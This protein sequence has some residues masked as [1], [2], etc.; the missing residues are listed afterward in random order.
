MSQEPNDKRH[1]PV[2][3]N[4]KANNIK[5]Q[6]N[7]VSL[8]SAIFVV[9]LVAVSSFILGARGSEWVS[10]FAASGGNRNKTAELDYAQLDALYDTL[11]TSYVGDLDNQKLIDGAKKGMAQATGDPYTEYFTDAEADEFFGELSGEFSGIGA[12]LGKKDEQLTIIST[13]D[14]TPA[15]KAGLKAGDVIAQVNEEDTQAWSIEEAVSNIRGEKGTTV[16]LTVIRE[17]EVLS[18]DVVRDDIVNPSVRSEVLD[19]N[20]GYIRLSR[21][22]DTDTV[23]LTR[24]FA[25]DLKQ[26]GVRGIV[27]D[28]RGNG[29]GYVK[30]AQEVAGVWLEDGKVVVEERQ[31]DKVLETL[32]ASGNPIL[33]GVP[34]V[35]LVDGGSASASEIVA[36]AFKD[37]GIATLVG[38][39]TFG[40]GSV[41]KIEQLTGGGQLKVTIAKWYTPKGQNIDKQGIEPKDKVELTEEDV[42][43]SRDPQ[44]DKAVE[45]LRQ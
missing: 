33:N 21:F 19:G 44:R 20:I 37:Y 38:Q 3:Q 10:T 6:T 25:Q 30:A 26:Q 5:R 31:G 9:V 27:L 39:K 7:G 29:G 35:V 32:R 2:R 43:A 17:G 28:L 40:K 42:K 1:A 45:L 15:Q 22:N 16:K 18:F 14:E 41:Q 4:D 12:E 8:K 34:T 13:I 24:Q 36:G 23:R 11:R